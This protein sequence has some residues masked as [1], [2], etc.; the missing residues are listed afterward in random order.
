MV[1]IAELNLSLY[2]LA[3][4]GKENRLKISGEKNGFY[5]Q[6]CIASKCFAL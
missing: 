5:F 2:L 4:R 1:P 6:Q 3:R